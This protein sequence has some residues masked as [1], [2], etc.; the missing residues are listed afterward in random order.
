MSFPGK[1]DDAGGVV[2]F[3]N[4][5]R[6]PVTVDHKHARPGIAKFAVP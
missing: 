1:H 3:G 4:A 2:R 6:I 5:E